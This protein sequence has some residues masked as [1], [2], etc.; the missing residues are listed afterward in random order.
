MC[1]KLSRAQ[2]LLSTD[3][4]VAIAIQESLLVSRFLIWGM[5]MSRP[6]ESSENRRV[7]SPPPKKSEPKNEN[8]RNQ[9]AQ[10]KRP[11]AVNPEK[12]QRLYISS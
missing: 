3:F 12:G 4:P 9:A 2:K 1:H 8:I 6:V 5:L 11:E 7:E 10:E